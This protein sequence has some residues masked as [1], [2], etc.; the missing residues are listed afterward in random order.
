MSAL[1]PTAG[2]HQ[3]ADNR[4]QPYTQ[5][6]VKDTLKLDG[7]AMLQATLSSNLDI[8]K[9]HVYIVG[10]SYYGGPTDPSTPGH[11]GYRGDDLDGTH[12]F[13][14]LGMGTDMGGL[15]RG[16]EVWVIY[17][18]QSVLATKLDIGAGGSNVDGLPRVIDLWYETA[19]A[20]GFTGTGPVMIMRKDGKAMALSA[21]AVRVNVSG[22]G[23]IAG[24]L[25][26][27]PSDAATAAKD[28]A[29]ATTSVA[30]FL[31]KLGQG[32]TWLLI[33]KVVAGVALVGFGLKLLISNAGSSQ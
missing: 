24:V 11:T 26:S 31:G 13:A 33:L 8:S 12:A 1:S 10:A 2:A 27:I 22:P 28:A 29:S 6:V 14:E 15:P 9:T 25:D 20:I 7:A 4:H 30:K 5:S 32:S 18:G 17:N 23:G 19:Q 21:G 16:T 3:T